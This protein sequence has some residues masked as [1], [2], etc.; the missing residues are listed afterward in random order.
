LDAL[1]QRPSNA[2]S[3]WL[4]NLAEWDEEVA[5]AIWDDYYGRMVRLARQKLEGFGVSRGDYDEE[6][7]ASD[8][9]LDF[10]RGM[11]KRQFPDLHSRDNLR[12]LLFTIT[13]RKANDRRKLCFTQKHGGGWVQVHEKSSPKKQLNYATIAALGLEV[14]FDDKQ[15][16]LNGLLHRRQLT[17]EQAASYNEDFIRRLKQLPNDS[18]RLIMLMIVAKF[19]VQEIANGLGCVKQ[20][21]YNKLKIIGNKKLDYMPVID[22]K[23]DIL[24]DAIQEYQSQLVLT[25]DNGYR[26]VAKDWLKGDTR[27]A[28]T[29][30]LGELLKPST[31]NSDIAHIWGERP[32]IDLF[33]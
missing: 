9:M 26:L 32:V 24:N 23:R 19:S 30:K 6:D 31:T 33:K 18:H 11:K 5:Q 29:K 20:T 7:V 4:T 16:G 15:S 14:Q 12:R 10:Y 8:A 1:L 22:S 17:P 21:V 28:I 13:V 3:Q 25:E 2:F 27:Q